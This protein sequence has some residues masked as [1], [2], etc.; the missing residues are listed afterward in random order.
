MKQR[1]LA[2]LLALAGHQQ[3][4][5]ELDAQALAKAGNLS[6]LERVYWEPLPAAAAVRPLAAATTKSN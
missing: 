2:G 6:P 1:V 4:A 3:R 5:L